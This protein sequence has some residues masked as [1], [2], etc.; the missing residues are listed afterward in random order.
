M[1]GFVGLAIPSFLLGLVLMYVGVTVFHADVSGLFS[2]EYLNAPWSW[3]RVRDLL[4]H[5]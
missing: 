1:A 2:P 4:A 5:L 3:G